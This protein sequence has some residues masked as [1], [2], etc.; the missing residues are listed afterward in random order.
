MLPSSA[1]RICSA[2][3]LLLLA[4]SALVAKIMPGVQKPHCSP[5]FAQ[6]ASWIGSSLP[7]SGATPSIVVT[8]EPSACAARHVHDFTA[9]PSS[10]TVHAPHW[11]VSQ[12]IL[13][14]V[15]LSVSR[16]K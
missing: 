3:G 10:C 5:C 4:S 14:P 6:N 13:V 9:T 16:R 2:D 8:D 7:P 11:L 12:P 1:W 15:R